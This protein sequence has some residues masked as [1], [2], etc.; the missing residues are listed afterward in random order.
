MIDDGWDWGDF[1]KWP[2]ASACHA[3]RDVTVRPIVDA[4]TWHATA[5]DSPLDAICVAWA[6]QCRISWVR[7]GALGKTND[8]SIPEMMP[9]VDLF[10]SATRDA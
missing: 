2:A 3:V 5:A 7:F 4:D 10:Q 9:H 1:V 8:F 6:N